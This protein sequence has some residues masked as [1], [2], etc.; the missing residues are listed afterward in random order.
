MTTGVLQAEPLLFLEQKNCFI[1][2]KQTLLIMNSCSLKLLRE[3]HKH[4]DGTLNSPLQTSAPPKRGALHKL[5]APST[6][7]P[8]SP[9]QKYNHQL[10]KTFEKTS[11]AQRITSPEDTKRQEHPRN[12]NYFPDMNSKRKH[13]IQS[14]SPKEKKGGGG[15]IAL[16]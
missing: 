8:T 11:K 15:E 3:F 1:S 16:W 10:A 14:C 13:L 5:R 7:T 6:Q 4:W 12:L 9:E 2:K